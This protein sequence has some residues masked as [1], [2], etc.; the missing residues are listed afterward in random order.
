MVLSFL[1]NCRYG[2]TEIGS[3]VVSVVCP[4]AELDT[5]NEFHQLSIF[6]EEEECRN[7]LTRKVTSRLMSNISTIKKHIDEGEFAQLVNLDGNDTISANF[8]EALVGLNL[9]CEDTG[10]E[11][12]AEWSP[13]VT[14]PANV[15]HRIMLTH[16]YYQPIQTT[17]DK[18]KEETSKATKIIGRIKMLESS[19]D[20]QTRTT[21]KITVVY[22]DEAEKRKTVTVKLE[23]SDYDKA[24]EAH[25]K[26][27]HV[28][29][30]GEL[31]PGRKPTMECESFGI[32][33]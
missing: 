20:V 14:P 25:G 28:E 15:Q 17:I 2:Q 8:Y 18:L 30:I 9:G 33:D 23:K 31:L 11:F 21:G 1:S 12:M 26:G 3:Y 4:F 24:I 32:I 27:S 5:S 13:I 10:V 22:L 6:S 19:P 29:I 7:S 16:D